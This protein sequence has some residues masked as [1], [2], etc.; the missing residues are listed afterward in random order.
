MSA[1]IFSDRWP[2]CMRLSLRTSRLRFSTS[3]CFGEHQRLE[4]LDIELVE[5]GQLVPAF[6]L[7][8]CR[9]HTAT[10]S[11]EVNNDIKICEHFG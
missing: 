2:K 8:A 11:R 4:R 5:I 10:M 9:V 7:A 6:R 3:V 1:F